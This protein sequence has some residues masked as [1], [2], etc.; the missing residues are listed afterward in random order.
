VILYDEPNAAYHANA[1]IGSGDIRRMLRSARLYADGLEGMCGRQ[2]DALQFGIASHM[3]LLEPER[4]EREFV[5]KPDGMSFATKEGKAWREQ[6]GSK[7]IIAAQDAECL[8]YM[9]ERMPADVAA[10]FAACRKEVTV[11]VDID[12]LASQCRPDLW[13]IDADA[14]YD[15]KTIP[16]IEGIDRAIWEHRLDVQLAWYRRVI[17]TETGRPVVKSPLIFVEKAPPYRWRIVELTLD[18]EQMAD[19]TVDEALAQIHARNRSG[20]WDDAGDLYRTVEVPKWLQAVTVGA[21][22]SINV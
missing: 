3:A 5:V 9:R 16:S 21:D 10:I 1:A 15:L 2:S 20:C 18:Y 8:H 4:F 12:G 13:N 22:G 6:Q 19:D 11:R 7:S 14:F 17:A